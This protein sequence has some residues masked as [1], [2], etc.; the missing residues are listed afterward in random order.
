ME[1]MPI[2]NTAACHGWRI[3]CPDDFIFFSVIFHLLRHEHRT[4]ISIYSDILKSIYITSHSDPNSIS[5]VFRILAMQASTFCEKAIAFNSNYFRHLGRSPAGKIPSSSGRGMYERLF[6]CSMLV[7]VR[8]HSKTKKIVTHQTHTASDTGRQP[9]RWYGEHF[10]ATSTWNI[11]VAKILN[12]T[13][14]FICVYMRSVMLCKL[15]N[16]FVGHYGNGWYVECQQVTMIWT[17]HLLL[18]IF[19]IEYYDLVRVNFKL[20]NCAIDTRISWRKYS[21][22]FIDVVWNKGYHG[23]FFSDII[24]IYMCRLDRISFPRN[25]ILIIWQVKQWNW[26]CGQMCIHSILYEYRTVLSRL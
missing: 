9:C 14:S 5:I 18:L 2:V 10:Y 21:F 13:I 8:L 7:C 20:E 17:R 22:S 4:L 6:A 3:Q 15:K 24:A 26:I 11:C 12:M 23:H 25:S 1:Q 16:R 19:I